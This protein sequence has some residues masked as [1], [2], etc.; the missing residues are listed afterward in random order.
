MF[1]LILTTAVALTTGLDFVRGIIE[2]HLVIV[3]KLD[4]IQPIGMVA[5]TIY[6]D[7]VDIRIPYIR[8]LIQVLTKV[9]E[10]R[11]SSYCQRLSVTL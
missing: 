4:D 7:A 5:I 8:F 3:G 9:I 10:H 11:T 2:I 1:A 6:I